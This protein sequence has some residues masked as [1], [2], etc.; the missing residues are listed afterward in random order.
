M[1]HKVY[2]N[3]PAFEAILT[4]TL[5]LYQINIHRIMKKNFYLSKLQWIY[6]NLKSIKILGLL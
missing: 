6:G 1:N 2:I 5:Y 3:K 4:P